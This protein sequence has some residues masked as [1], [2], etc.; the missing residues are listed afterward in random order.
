MRHQSTAKLLFSVAALAA[1]LLYSLPGMASTPPKLVFQKTLEDVPTEEENGERFAY[2]LQEEEHVYSVLRRF[3]VPARIK[4][5]ILDQT[6]QV[7]PQ[8]EDLDQV[9][10]GQVV[11]FPGSVK[12]YMEGEPSSEDIPDS[13]I[14]H[15]EYSISKGEHI[16]QVLRDMGIPEQRIFREYIPLVRELNPDIDNIH[17]LEPGMRVTLP[18]PKQPGPTSP[19]HQFAKKQEPEAAEAED[20]EHSLAT[21]E[22]EEPVKEEKREESDLEKDVGQASKKLV[23]GVLREIGLTPSR[24]QE[25]L[26][27]A[28]QG[29]LHLNLGRTPLL[30]TPWG[31]SILL[32]PE[33]YNTDDKQ[34]RTEQTDLRLC[35][36]DDS[37]PPAETFHRLEEATDRRLLFWDTGQSLILNYE[38]MVLELQGS[39]LFVL[40]KRED[41]EHYAFFRGIDPQER[42]AGLL[43]EFLRKKGIR[44]Y[45]LQGSE[46]E[47]IQP[48][49][50]EHLEEEGLKMQSFRYEEV[51]PR[52]ER[53]LAEK[54]ASPDPPL[55]HQPSALLEYL[56]EKDLA[57]TRSLRVELLNEPEEENHISLTLKT[58]AID[59]GSPTLVL[60]E[61]TADPHLCSL[62]QKQGYDCFALQP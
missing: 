9:E 37:W 22:P 58:T 36:V 56:R 54:E 59:L 47:S 15:K 26:Y 62:L 41:T 14:P 1:L 38:Q 33:K 4:P 34:Q 57:E 52:V 32:L 18:V 11:Y 27:P 19:A 31:D 49:A 29:W 24:Q 50:S 2:T 17:H 6:R 16:A 5:G 43:A 30:D 12:D 61:K 55:S 10:S 45:A 40:Q 51:W 48:L 60:G 7:N 25:I 42:R 13:Q 53:V 35:T 44:A 39:Y 28:S 3:G 8:V 21:P 20:R 46:L 23:L